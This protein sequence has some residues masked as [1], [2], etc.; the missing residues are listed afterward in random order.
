M[1]SNKNTVGTLSFVLIILSMLLLLCWFGREGMKSNS[2]YGTFRYSDGMTDKQLARSIG[3]IHFA[4]NVDGNSV[5]GLNDLETNM[6]NRMAGKNNYT[7]IRWASNS[8]TGLN[9]YEGVISDRD[10]E[11]KN[12][13]LPM[14]LV[15]VPPNSSTSTNEV[16]ASTGGVQ[17]ANIDWSPNS[18][19]FIYGSGRGYVTV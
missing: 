15:T 2:L 3:G 5:E 16:C 6:V 17:L 14:E 9:N 4:N 12:S 19:A 13:V 11:R 10:V 7:D 18:P 8:L 1:S